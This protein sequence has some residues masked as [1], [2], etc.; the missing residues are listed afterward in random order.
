[1]AMAESAERRYLKQQSAGFYLIQRILTTLKIAN[2]PEAVI[3][4]IGVHLLGNI[5]LGK[6]NFSLIV[7]LLLFGDI[8]FYIIQHACLEKINKNLLHMVF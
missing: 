3:Q 7:I 8:D 6:I 1:M 2:A 5:M 4:L